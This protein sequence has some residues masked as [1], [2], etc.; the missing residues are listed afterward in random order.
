MTLNPL[1]LKTQIL[2]SFNWNSNFLHIMNSV[3]EYVRRWTKHEKEDND[4]MSEWTKI[5]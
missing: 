1:F 3:E 2:G 4:T 5:L